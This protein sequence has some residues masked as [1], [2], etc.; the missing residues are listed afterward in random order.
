MKPCVAHVVT[1]QCLQQEIL[2]RISGSLPLGAPVAPGGPTAAALWQARRL[3]HSNAPA[4]QA[5]KQIGQPFFSL[6][7]P[8]SANRAAVQIS[9]ALRASSSLAQ[10]GRDDRGRDDCAA[11]LLDLLGRIAALARGPRQ[12]SVT[13]LAWPTRH[14]GMVHVPGWMLAASTGRQCTNW[15]K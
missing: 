4:S 11:I 1:C 6:F 13:G 10:R 9:K 7:S 15:C 12:H 2:S 14:A 3:P 5:A 8:I